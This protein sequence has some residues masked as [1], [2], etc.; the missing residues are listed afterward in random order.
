MEDI[1]KLD[2][3]YLKYSE[4]AVDKAK[5]KKALKDGVELEGV[6]LLKTIIFRLSRSD[7]N[8]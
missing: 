6:N 7:R 4:P 1:T 8:G 3:D 5:V 2:D